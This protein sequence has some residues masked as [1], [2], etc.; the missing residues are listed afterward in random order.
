MTLAIMPRYGG[1]LTYGERERLVEIY[2]RLLE[3]YVERDSAVARGDP[4]L[5]RALRREIEELLQAKAQ[6]KQWATVGSA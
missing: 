3:L 2:D 5:A 4:E 1:D 6:I